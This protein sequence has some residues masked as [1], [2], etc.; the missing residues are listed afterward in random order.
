MT[1]H[2]ELERLLRTIFGRCEKG[3]DPTLH[4][5]RRRDFVFHL[6]DWCENLDELFDLYHHP[7][8]YK[9]AEA[10]KIVMGFLYHAIPHL[11]TA[12]R[13]LLDEIPDAFAND[14]PV[15]EVKP[16]TS[17]RANKERRTAAQ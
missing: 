7:E 6:T 16:N 9:P 14:W 13:L 4:A 5:M 8:K 12:G 11:K 3:E 1:H 2:P 10:S 15:D 17:V